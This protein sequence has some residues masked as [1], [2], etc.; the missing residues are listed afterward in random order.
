[1]AFQ[2][3]GRTRALRPQ[4]WLIYGRSQEDP[5]EVAKLRAYYGGKGL[6]VHSYDNLRRPNEWCKDY[7][8]VR[9]RGGGAYTALHIPPTLK[10]TA[11]CP[12]SWRAVAGRSEAVGG[13]RGLS[14][15]RKTYLI[16]QIPAWDAWAA[17]WQGRQ[18]G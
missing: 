4:Y 5:I 6:N 15:V 11:S 12:E 14:E 13:A 2:Q 9:S 18:V 16:D 8:T 17:F 7:L 3:I 10:W 1:M